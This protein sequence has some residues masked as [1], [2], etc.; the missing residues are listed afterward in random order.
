MRMALSR[1]AREECRRTKKAI[2]V[3]VW[4]RWMPPAPGDI[5]WCRFPN[6]PQRARVRNLGLRS[7]ATSPA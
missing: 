7:C 3:L 1:M 4:A 5:V 2:A 6:L